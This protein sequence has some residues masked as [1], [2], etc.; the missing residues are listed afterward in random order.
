[1]HFPPAF[2]SSLKGIEGFHLPSFEEIHQ[3]G[4]QVTSIRLNPA[5]L[6]GP[7]ALQFYHDINGSIPWCEQ[8]YY[9][10]NRP[11]FTFDPL[12]HSGCYYVQEAS[13]MF[14]EQALKQTVN[15]NQPI[16]VL[17][18][19]AA[20][21]GKSTHLQ[22][23]VTAD[24]LLVSNEIIQTRVNIL[25]DNIMRWGASNTIVTRNDP[26]HFSR[27]NGFFD[28]IVVDAP[29][30]GSGLFR[31]DND[32]MN[33][34]SLSNVE[35]CCQRQQKILKD[36]WPALKE[37]GVLIYSTCSYSKEENE[38]IMDWLM[39]SFPVENMIIQIPA[40]VDI[41]Q[42]FS[43]INNAAG[44]RFYPDKI[45]GEGFFISCFQKLEGNG[46]HQ[47][48]KPRKLEMARQDDQEV[49][50]SWITEKDMVF[51]PFFD[52][53][54]AIPGNLVNDYAMIS[55]IMNIRYAGVLM[56]ELIRGKLVPHHSLALSLIVADNINRIH[57]DREDAIRY[58]QRKNLKIDLEY[59]GWQLASYNDH[60]IG[61]VNVLPNRIN[62]Y[63]P[64][65]LRI[66]KEFE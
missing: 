22:S 4:E 60:N 53:V 1:M 64:K 2:L 37:G 66:L 18:L 17:D 31:R 10:N 40:G 16:K 45:Q 43:S 54:T 35:L 39:D 42:T 58:L 65:E 8:G 56:G 15:L 20:P 47:S 23:M 33:E 38:E 13:S 55:S 51:L 27:L 25:T 36:V 14:L 44:Y 19:C 21:G 24:S 46:Y 3:S 48:K 6:N 50:Q 49:L 32:A 12:F 61:W 28:V 11:S 62:N 41:I 63:Y 29:C 30:S 26:S 34:W 59:K 7:S 9:L 57:L 52:K 5:K